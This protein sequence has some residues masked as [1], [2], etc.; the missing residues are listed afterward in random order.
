MARQED[1]DLLY[2][3]ALPTELIVWHI[4]GEDVEVRN[5]FLPRNYLSD[6]EAKLGSSLT[7]RAQDKD[8]R[9]E[10]QTSRGIFLVLIQPLLRSI[11]TRLCVMEPHEHLDY[12][13][14]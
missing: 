8:A 10:E 5:V 13:P 1:Y 2:C 9:V 11:K 4:G 6:K 7:V 14:F 12:A 3:L